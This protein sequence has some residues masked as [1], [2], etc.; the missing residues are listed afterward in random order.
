LVYDA[1]GAVVPAALVDWTLSGGG[2]GAIAAD[3]L[4]TAPASIAVAATDTVIAT[5]A[6]GSAQTSVLVNLH[7]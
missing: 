3:G 5:Y 7:P 1:S 6:A 4:Y 2:T